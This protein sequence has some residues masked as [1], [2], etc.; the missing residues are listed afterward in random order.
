M[1]PTVIAE[2]SDSRRRTYLMLAAAALT[3]LALV[4]FMIASVTRAA[5]TDTTR[6]DGNA[7]DTGTVSLTDSQNGTAMFTVDNLAPGDVVTRSITVTNA[8]SLPLDV[9]LYGENLQATEITNSLLE[10]EKLSEYLN[11]KIGTTS[12]GHDVYTGTGIGTL[13]GF[14]TDHTGWA[15]GTSAIDLAAGGTQTYYLWV[16]LDSDTPQGF[17][18]ASAEIDFVWEGQS[19]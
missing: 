19:Q 1:E 17:E 18:G 14:A 8:G 15:N 16:E 13:L 11:V 5:W 10:T 2:A 3:A 4:V 9:K 12:G 6:N 7:W